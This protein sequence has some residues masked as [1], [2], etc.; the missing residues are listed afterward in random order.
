MLYRKITTPLLAVLLGLSFSL[1]NG[2]CSAEENSSNINERISENSS[3]SAEV[4]PF[5]PSWL[6]YGW[7][8]IKVG[9]RF[10]ERR[11]NLS[12]ETKVE[13]GVINL[14]SPSIHYNYE[15]VQSEFFFRPYVSKGVRHI[16]MHAHRTM[17]L[18]VF[19]SIALI[20]QDPNGNTKAQLTANSNQYLFYDP[21]SNDPEGS[22]KAQYIHTGGWSWQNYFRVRTTYRA[23]RSLS[24]GSF[25]KDC[26]ETSIYYGADNRYFVEREGFSHPSPNLLSNVIS[27]EDLSNQ[28]FDQKGR[29]VDDLKDYSLGDKIT[30]AGKLVDIGYDDSSDV[31]SLTF[32]YFDISLNENSQFVWKFRNNLTKRFA[33]GDDL[34][35]K[36]SVVPVGSETG[37]TFESIDYFEEARSISE[38]VYPDIDKY[39]IDTKGER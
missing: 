24:A 13:D 18:D 27:F 12:G 32:Q 3:V 14:V 38:G 5:F 35:F 36:M 8:I 23:T 11:I 19:S 28:F 25:C 20:L 4:P 31:T 37:K 22:W 34:T 2:V 10:V 39:L 33:L 9:A 6:K 21:Q 17:P 16:D 26:G 1:P 30:V 15:D 7:E 29:I